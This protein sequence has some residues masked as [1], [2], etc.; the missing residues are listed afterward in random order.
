MGSA[1]REVKVGEVEFSRDMV[2]TMLENFD[3]YAVDGVL[4]LEVTEGGRL[5]LPHPHSPTRQFLGLARL[6]HWMNN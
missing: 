1:H 3:F 5:W 4:R 6:P 2:E